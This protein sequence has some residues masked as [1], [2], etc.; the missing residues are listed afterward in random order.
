MEDS[1]ISGLRNTR[2]RQNNVSVSS[3]AKQ[4][5]LSAASANFRQCPLAQ[6]GLGRIVFCRPQ[7]PQHLLHGV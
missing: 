2:S 5:P 1:G 4:F 6:S 7:M 3:R